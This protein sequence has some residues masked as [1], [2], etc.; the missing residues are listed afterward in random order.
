MSLLE[1]YNKCEEKVIA[2]VGENLEVKKIKAIKDLPKE[3]LP[4]EKSFLQLMSIH[5]SQWLCNQFSQMAWPLL[6]LIKFHYSIPLVL[7]SP[8]N[9]IRKE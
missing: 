8:I 6:M 2:E 4:G 9:Q 7:L 1:Y 3:Y 5:F